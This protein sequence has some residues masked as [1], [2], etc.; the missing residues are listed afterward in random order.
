MAF[1]MAWTA[2]RTHSTSS[3][4]S[5]GGSPPRQGRSHGRS[6]RPSINPPATETGRD[7]GPAW[8]ILLARRLPG[9]ARYLEG[10]E[11]REFRHWRGMGPG[12]VLPSDEALIA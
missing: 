7:A 9:V 4:A 2:W 11:A 6:A 5:T 8:P 12:E 3:H 1:R 10:L